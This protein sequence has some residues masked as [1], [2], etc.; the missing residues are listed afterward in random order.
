MEDG[1][2]SLMSRSIIIRGL[3]NELHDEGIITQSE[4]ELL[5]DW[6]ASAPSEQSPKLTL[7]WSRYQKVDWG[8]ECWIKTISEQTHRV[9]PP[10]VSA[11]DENVELRNIG[12][13]QQVWEQLHSIGRQKEASPLE[14]LEMTLRNHFGMPVPQKW[15]RESWIQSGI[16]YEYSDWTESPIS[17]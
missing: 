4:K 14:T 16:L 15:M 17:L 7:L 12:L 6:K 3:I 8:K 1:G 2:Q 13:S 9:M 11:W 10:E 5:N